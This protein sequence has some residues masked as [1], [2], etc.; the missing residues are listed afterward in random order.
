MSGYV[1]DP[2]IL[3]AV[4]EAAVPF[5]EKPFTRDGLAKKVR[6]AIDTPRHASVRPR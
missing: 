4:Q 1:D 6:E 2:V 3:Q 5:L